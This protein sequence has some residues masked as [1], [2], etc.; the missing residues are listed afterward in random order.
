MMVVF[1]TF[2]LVTYRWLTWYDGQYTSRGPSGNHA[3]PAGA[4]PATT[5][6]PQCAPPTQATSAGA[7]TGRT[8]ATP[9][10]ALSGGG[11]RSTIERS[12]LH[13]PERAECPH[14]TDRCR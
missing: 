6:T 9:P 13:R 1:E 8:Y 14:P 12:H 5:P 10:T 2:T 11:G 4:P 3:T 7:Y